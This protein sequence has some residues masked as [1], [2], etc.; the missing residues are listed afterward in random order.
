MALLLT[1]IAIAI[2]AVL[3]FRWGGSIDNIIEWRPPLWEALVGGVAILVLVDLIGLSGGFAAFLVL[4]ATAAILAFAV[5]N[6]RVGGMVLLVAGL[7]LNFL[8]T[9]LNWGMP[10]RANALVSANIV[11]QKDLPN[12]VLSGGR[13]ISDGAILGFLGD[14]IPLPWGHVVSIGDLLILAGTCLV[15]ASVMRVY[16]VGGG[17]RGYAGRRG[18]QDYSVAMEA[19][20]RGPAPRRGPGL[21]PSRM[22]Q[23]GPQLG[24]PRRGRSERGRQSI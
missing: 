7:G 8:V 5:I 24:G 20:G 12:V 2:G 1:V 11:E 13:S 9:L 10:V 15:T 22:N 18:P 6:I 16:Q 14:S 19:L 21:H 23:K 17:R 3:G 4:L